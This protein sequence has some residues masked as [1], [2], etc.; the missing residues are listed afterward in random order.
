MKADSF[1][2]IYL[3]SDS[4][5]EGV[6]ASQITPLILGL[7][8]QGLKVNLVTLEKI[9]PP[10]DHKLIFSQAGVVWSPQPFGR[11]GSLG[12]VLRLERLSRSVQNSAL[13]H[14]R[15]DLAT[16]AG[17][18]SKSDAPILWDVRSLWAD[19][20]LAIGGQGW[21][22]LTAKGA[23]SL[24][25]LSA[26]R[27]IGMT[28]LTS[29]VVPILQERHRSLPKIQDV[30][31]TCVQ[32]EKFLPAS[33]PTG[34]I[35][36]L[37]SG[38]FNNFYDLDRTLEIVSELRKSFEL[39]VI[40]A[41]PTEATRSSLG[42]GEEVRNSISHDEMPS[43]VSQSHFGIAVCQQDEKES[44]TA[45][46][47]TKVGEFLASGRPMIVSKGI[48]DL[49]VLLHSSK[50]GLIISHDEGLST[51]GAKLVELI[52]DPSTPSRCRSLAMEHF[53]MSSA[54]TRYLAV[55]EKMISS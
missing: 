22:L 41:R 53:D 17:I 7:G 43:L 46:V 9:Q 12:G 38:T 24:E 16:A 48:G 55:Y 39:K 29:A 26:K 3:T 15:S 23:R 36:C 5:Q 37:M 6:G 13:I 35:T 27:A 20:R 2:L 44:L 42:L 18:L 11:V 45:A 8:K 49:D 47:P 14:G 52:E 1:D 25:N 51:L 28:T 54:I 10:E 32:T 34:T 40:W 21:N 31:P 4:I 30:I 50:T 33:M 19:Q